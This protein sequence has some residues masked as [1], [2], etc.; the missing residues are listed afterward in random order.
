MI[1]RR[2]FITLVGGVAA[3]WP[4]AGRAQ[5]PATIPKVGIIFPRPATA[6]ADNI[7]ALKNGLRDL[8]Y[9]EGETFL[10]DWY[11]SEGNYEQ[12]PAVVERMITGGANLL[13]VGGTTPAI[14]VRKAT[15]KPIV[16]VGVSDPVGAGLAESL[17]HP[18]G[19]ATGLATAH[20]EAY[21]QKSLELLKEIIPSARHVAV[22][23]NPANPFNVTFLREVQ[24]AAN[25]LRV[26]LNAFEPA[27]RRN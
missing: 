8:G 25:T 19:N 12:I 21:A 27:L 7:A 1:G 16:F 6:A 22:L 4:I 2:E 10:A 5:Q 14:I 17:A 26:E 3:A 9:I 24:R 13:L 23:Y 15:T 18:G 11:F 20:E